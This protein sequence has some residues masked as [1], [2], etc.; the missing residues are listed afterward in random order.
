MA[1]MWPL[2]IMAVYNTAKSRIINGR[3][4]KIGVSKRALNLPNKKE[5]TDIQSEDPANDP[6]SSTFAIS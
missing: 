5:S 3:Y 6:D 4:R 2:T 1:L